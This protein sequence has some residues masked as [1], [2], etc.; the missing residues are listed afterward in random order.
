MYF[1]RQVELKKNIAGLALK[2]FGHLDIGNMWMEM[3]EMEEDVCQCTI[4]FI[5]AQILMK[6][7]VANA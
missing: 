5:S 7:G 2:C 6:Q 1:S 4:F 3:E